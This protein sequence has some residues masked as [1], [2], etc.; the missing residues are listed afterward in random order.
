M[1]T[2]R[3]L[4]GGSVEKTKTHMRFLAPLRLAALANAH[5]RPTFVMCRTER[6]SNE[7]FFSPPNML[8]PHPPLPR[9]LVHSLYPCLPIIRPVSLPVRTS[10]LATS[11][12]RPILWASNVLYTYQPSSPAKSCLRQSLLLLLVR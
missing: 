4:N 8:G 11:R 6:E 1:R 10:Q 2:S 5:V 12:Y 7:S 9:K 3:S